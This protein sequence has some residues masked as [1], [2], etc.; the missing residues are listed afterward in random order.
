M[1]TI[2][3][4][5]RRAQAQRSSGSLPG[6]YTAN[7]LG[8]PATAP[9]PNR[10]PWW[11][12]LVGGAALLLAGA[13]V[14]AL[15]LLPRPVARPESAN[16]PLQTLPKLP[17]VASSISPA[18]AAQPAPLEARAAS[19]ALQAAA[20]PP[21]AVP[22]TANASSPVRLGAQPDDQVVASAS[23][24]AASG[25]SAQALVPPKKGSA[26][27]VPKPAPLDARLPSWAELAPA[28]QGQMPAIRL[29]G[30][31]YA[32]APGQR[33]VL[34]NGQVAREGDEVATGVRLIQIR[35]RS[36]VL[37]FQGQRFEMPM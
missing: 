37:E 2:L 35:P 5:L 34:V 31:V 14:A 8:V 11:L 28:L 20:V 10:A 22:S 19:A 1:S 7:P 27:A 17:P 13:A 18:P 9:H 4:A 21:T 33:L 23:S 24:R 15:W 3:D 32:E 30:G 29:G 26:S 6:L 12:I 16:V 36:A 25:R